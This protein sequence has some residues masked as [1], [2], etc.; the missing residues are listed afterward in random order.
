MTV[1]IT[2]TNGTSETYTSVTGFAN[3]GTIV[4]FKGK[5]AGREPLKDWQIN[6]ASVTKIEMSQ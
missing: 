1:T 5:L 2:Y 3:N 4:S 6:W